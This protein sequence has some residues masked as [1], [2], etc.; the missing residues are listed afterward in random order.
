M[1]ILAATAVFLLA[2]AGIAVLAR[3]P[4]PQARSRARRSPARPR[5]SVLVTAAKAAGVKVGSDQLPH[6]TAELA[7]KA[8]GG[9]AR[10][11]GRLTRWGGR[12]AGRA[13]L[14]AGRWAER[15]AGRRWQAR[16]ATPPSPLLWRHHDPATDQPEPGE[17]PAADQPGPGDSPT[18]ADGPP[19]GPALPGTT[20][21][22]SSPPTTTAA[23]DGAPAAPRAGAGRNTTMRHRYSVNLERPATDAEFLESCVQ[24]GDVLKALAEEVSDWADSLS[25]LNLPQSVLAPLHLV[26]E[27]I[28]EAASGASQSAK[29]FEDEF[30]DA[31]DVASRGMHFT[32]ED[33]A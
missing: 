9:T 27:G 28:E 10:G 20:T 30:E 19:P 5:K 8:A 11:T 29:A 23:P 2:L 31:R 14:A 32:G 16:T 3:Q 12:R 7:G 17:S 1:E 26:S 22:A 4:A 18:A 33:A 6:A 24:L 21:A 25:G 13:G 15:Q